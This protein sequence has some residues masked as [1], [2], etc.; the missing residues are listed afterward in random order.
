MAA[1]DRIQHQAFTPSSA[2]LG[3]AEGHT[4]LHSMSPL[5]SIMLLP[6][7]L[8][9]TGEVTMGEAAAVF[10]KSLTLETASAR[11]TTRVLWEGE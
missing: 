8:D 6:C 4:L 3:S 11:A 1:S 9:G 2:W 7:R 10:S 5:T